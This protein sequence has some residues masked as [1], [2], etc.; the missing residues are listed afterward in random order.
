[1]M[2]RVAVIALDAA[3]WQ[4]VQRLME[5]GELPN[6]TRLQKVSAFC[7]MR[8]GSSWQIDRVWEAFV[9]GQQVPTSSTL[10]DPT[11][12]GTRQLGARRLEPFFARAGKV[13]ALDVPMMSLAYPMEGAQVIGWGTHTSG[14]PKTSRPQGLLNEIERRFGP[15][16]A[17]LRQHMVRW[18]SES[19]ITSMAD[20]M[21][22]GASRR[23]EVVDWLLSRVPD[24]DFFITLLPEAHGAG[25]M[26]WYGVDDRFPVHG[27][28][29]SS[30]AEAQF[31][32]VLRAMDE[33]VGRII[34]LLPEDTSVVV[35][36]LHGMEPNDYDL[37][38][39][40]LFP[41]LMYRLQFGRPYLKPARA[42]SNGGPVILGERDWW[43]AYMERRLPGFPLGLIRRRAPD[44]VPLLKRRLGGVLGGRTVSI[45][46]TETPEEIGEPLSPMDYQISCRY[47][48]FWPR[49][50][51]FALPAYNHARFRINLQGRER[52][53][54]VP[55]ESYGA[56]L[57]Q[58]EA[59]L[60]AC[61]DPRTGEPVLGK[62][63]RLRED[64]PL[65]R[66]NPEDDLGVMMQGV[67]DAIDHPKAGRIGPYP[68]HRTGGHSVRGFAFVDGPGIAP[69]EL[70]E[71][72]FWDLAPTIL[73][74][75][76]AEPPAP[77]D[78]E[79]FLPLLA[80]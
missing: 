21:V 41:E 23:V 57:D 53:G 39:Q 54:I 76:G 8:H 48:E 3:E 79:S 38:A 24:W 6:L 34:A 69:R 66:D 32:R 67:V 7:T 71:R 12:Y 10:F 51:A 50:R 74:L 40:V 16:V 14:Y 37:P 2:S 17:E 27:L 59:E 20:A 19:S 60:R 47:R 28:A 11:T 77:L 78:G 55:P 30:T 26:L 58:L 73:G 72:S 5:E 13:V 43:I 18:Q 44:L 63:L 25:E 65:S 56:A 42:S 70:G 29:A 80:S 1:M 49:M 36:A 68:F 4:W 31:R 61:R 75:L 22:A 62:V 9:A 33:S 15:Y 46:T 52:D 45:E 35:T 64:D